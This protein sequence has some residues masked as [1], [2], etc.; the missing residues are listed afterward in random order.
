MFG[1]LVIV[2][3]TPHEGG[4]L[5]L[6]HRGQEWIFDSDQAL[7]AKGKPSIGY[8][9]FFSD[10]EHEV[11]PVISGHR[12]TLTYNLYFDDGGPVS[13]SDAVSKH[14]TPP[15][16]ANEDAIHKAFV[17]LLENPDFLEEGGTLAFGLRHVY[18]IKRKLERVF[19][20][21]KSRCPIE[22]Y[23]HRIYYVLKASDAVAY[24]NAFA[25]GFE[26]KLYLYYEWR[27]SPLGVIIDKVIDFD[28][29]LPL[30]DGDDLVDIAQK[31][32][33]ILVA[34]G[35]TNRGDAIELDERFDSPEL[36]EWVTP[37]TT[38]NRQVDAYSTYGE[39]NLELRWVYGYVCLI[40]RIGKARDRLAYPTVAELNECG[41]GIGDDR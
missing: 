5:R 31:E 36:L 11:A 23:L 32:G 6:Y 28:E 15:K 2:F 33:G 8:V 27:G 40:V 25:L 18:P 38:F 24:Q 4:A 10:I 41:C 21:M 13:T 26:P 37:M 7:A 17:A 16:L 30:D 1:S 39:K 34:Q 12:I 29:G 19:S 9:A 3:P 35:G 14:L 20:L 22:N